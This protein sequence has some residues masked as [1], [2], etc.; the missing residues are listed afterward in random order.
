MKKPNQDMPPE[1]IKTKGNSQK[2]HNRSGRGHRA[3]PGDKGYGV[4]RYDRN[5][6]RTS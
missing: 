1:H 2:R 6:S 3:D 4:S 5:V